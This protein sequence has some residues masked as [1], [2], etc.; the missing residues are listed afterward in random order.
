MYTNVIIHRYRQHSRFCY[1]R[2]SMVFR[3]RQ[4]FQPRDKHG[5]CTRYVQYPLQH[6]N[7]LLDN[8]TFTPTYLE[9]KS[10]INHHRP[11]EHRPNGYKSPVVSHGQRRQT[12]VKLRRLLQ[13]TL[14]GQPL[15]QIR[16]LF[17]GQT[18]RVC[19][20]V[21]RGLL[22]FA[23]YDAEPAHDLFIF[24]KENKC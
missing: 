4:E 11:A 24:D 10:D 3:D 7:Q 6:P 22:V 13:D 8:F 18:R 21:Q 19:Q 5:M 17:L 20:H 2:N 16:L 23:L 15:L 12:L 1:T 14:V 9:T